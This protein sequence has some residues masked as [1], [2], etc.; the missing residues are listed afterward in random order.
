LELTHIDSKARVSRSHLVLRWSQT[1]RIVF[2][3]S[4]LGEGVLKEDIGLF[5]LRLFLD[6]V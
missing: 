2:G 5:S 6:L 4:Q 1:L 3:S